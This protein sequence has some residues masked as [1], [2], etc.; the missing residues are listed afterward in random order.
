[1][2]ARVTL[3]ALAMAGFT[4]DTGGDPQLP[5]HCDFSFRKIKN[6]Q[7]IFG[8]WLVSLSPLALISPSNSITVT[9]EQ[10]WF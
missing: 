6:S 10:V 3:D 5:L 4:S 7:S 2:H 1:M 9:M 8:C